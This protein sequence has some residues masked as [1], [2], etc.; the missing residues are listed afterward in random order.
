MD[1]VVRKEAIQTRDHAVPP[2][3]RSGPYSDGSETWTE[4]RVRLR[5]RLRRGLEWKAWP[6]AHP[7]TSK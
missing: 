3:R 2:V 6:E 7:G 1:G 5:A 4:W